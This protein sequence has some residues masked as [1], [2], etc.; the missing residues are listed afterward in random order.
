[1]EQGTLRA[2][3]GGDLDNAGL[4]ASANGDVSLEVNGTLSNHGTLFSKQAMTLAGGAIDN[5]GQLQSA[6]VLGVDAASLRNRAQATWLASSGGTFRVG[7]LTNEGV[8]VASNNTA[9]AA[10]LYLDSL[11]NSGTLQGA[12]ALT[13]DIG[14]TLDSSGKLLAGETLTIQGSDTHYTLAASGVVQ[15]GETL[16]ITGENAGQGV[17][18]TLDGRAVLLSQNVT[19]NVAD[20]TLTDDAHLGSTGNLAVTANNLSVNS[21][22]SRIV[23]ATNSGHTTLTLTGQF[24]NQGAVHSGGDLQLSAASVSNGSTAGLSALGELAVTAT[25]ANIDNRGA[26]YAADSL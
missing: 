5:H 17:D 21:A 15:A 11:D 8:L 1:A 4:M 25:Q 6:G 24:S 14:S 20:I 9:Q 19:L 16:T 10:R 3:V 26:L 22:T 13:L 23:G 18:V 12:G 2:N 7:A